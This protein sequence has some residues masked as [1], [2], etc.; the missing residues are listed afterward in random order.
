M[1]KSK[2]SNLINSVVFCRW[3]DT[4]SYDIKD[5]NTWLR[6]IGSLSSQSIIFLTF[7]KLIAEDEQVI[8]I[9]PTLAE[10][11]EDISN[12]KANDAVSIPKGCILEIKELEF[13]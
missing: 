9:A 2:Y 13:K 3:M 10:A 8:L 12:R 6:K 5:L 4:T 1:K 11:N 7:G